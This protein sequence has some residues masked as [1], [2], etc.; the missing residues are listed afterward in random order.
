MSGRTPLDPYQW[1]EAALWLAK[2]A[3]D[4]AVAHLL[5]REDFVFPASFH[6]QQALEKV[7]KALLVAASQDIRRTHDLDDL[8][9]EANQFWP[10]LIPSPFPLAELSRWYLS[11]RYPG[12]DEMPPSLGEIAQALREIEELIAA[13][14]SWMSP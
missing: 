1:D 8:A 7:L 11:S 5:I 12:I 3:E 6:A 13:I 4:L 9:M 14:N 10:T 2:A